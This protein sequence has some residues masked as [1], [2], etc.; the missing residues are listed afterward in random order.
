MDGEREDAE[1]APAEELVMVA[2]IAAAIVALIL[3]GPA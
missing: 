2:W 1:V 3:L